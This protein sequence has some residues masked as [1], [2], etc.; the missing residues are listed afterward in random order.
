MT[1]PAPR[2]LNSPQTESIIKWMSRTQTC[3]VPEERR[4]AR[5]KFLQ[6]APVALLTTTGRRPVSRE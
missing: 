1:K 4:Q 3:T 5:G 2:G 6:G